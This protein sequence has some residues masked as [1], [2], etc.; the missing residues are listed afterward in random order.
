[1]IWFANLCFLSLFPLEVV[2]EGEM[3]SLWMGWFGSGD[4]PWQRDGKDD[5]SVPG[6]GVEG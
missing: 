3:L 2:K 5:P 4:A 6:P 1:M